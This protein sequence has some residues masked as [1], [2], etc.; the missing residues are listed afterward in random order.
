MGL[1]TAPTAP[2]VPADPP[3]PVM[4][5][6]AYLSFVDT[7]RRTWRGSAA[8]MFGVPVLQLLAFGYGLGHLIGRTNGPVEGVTYVAFLAPGLVAASAMQTALEEATWSVMAAIKWQRTYHAMLAT[9]LT[10]GQI[11]LSHLL[12]AATMV[13]MSTAVLLLVIA[14]LG[15]GTGWLVLALPAAV[16]VGLAFAAPAMAMTARSEDTQSLTYLYRFG[17]VPLFLFSGT[18][19]PISQLPA[20][21]ER[22]AWVTPLWH[23][24]ALCRDLVLGRVGWLDLVHV[25]YLL[26]LLAVGLLLA[27]RAF[28]RRLVV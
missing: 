16:L 6:R 11:L 22:L 21:L 27:D 1:S 13:A 20:W 4:V 15:L 8:T 12:W 7:F 18:F 24:V 10:A 26:A 2:T 5:G 28:R 9:P 23:G 17:V 19:F 14:V 25:G 3:A